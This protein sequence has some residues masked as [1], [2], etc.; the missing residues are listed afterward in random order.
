[1]VRAS[2]KT[3][4]K[5]F[6]KINFLISHFFILFIKFYRLFFSPFVGQHCRFEPSCSRYAEEA[7]KTHG[8]LKGLFFTIRRLLRCHPWAKAG[9]DPVP[10]NCHHCFD[11]NKKN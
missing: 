1:M 8:S 11:L 3:G 9:Y 6:M 4:C 2:K 7:I 10:S 5:R